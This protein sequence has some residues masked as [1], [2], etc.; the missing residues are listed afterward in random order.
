MS[1]SGLYGPDGKLISP[2]AKYEPELREISGSLLPDYIA[3]FEFNGMK[4]HS[5]MHFVLSFKVEGEHHRK[6]AKAPT[7]VKARKLVKK[8]GTREDWDEVRDTVMMQALECKYFQCRDLVQDLLDTWPHH[9]LY[10]GEHP[11][12]GMGKSVSGKSGKNAYGSLLQKVRLTLVG[13]NKSAYGF[14]PD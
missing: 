4:F 7:L 12:W 13:F 3:R 8:L 14:K 2:V 11:H 5:V 10:K 9:L 1:G 6:V